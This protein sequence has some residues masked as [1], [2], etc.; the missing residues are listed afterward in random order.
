MYG[1]YG[2]VKQGLL[3]VMHIF[4]RSQLS[5]IV[6][7]CELVKIMEKSFAPKF[8]EDERSLMIG[9]MK[10]D[11]FRKAQCRDFP[12]GQAVKTVLPM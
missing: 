9:Y 2:R 5:F 1:C 11:L 8:L 7:S 4:G 10:I 6:V 3:A 12:G